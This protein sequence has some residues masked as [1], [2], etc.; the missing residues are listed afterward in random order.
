MYSRTSLKARSPEGGGA[1]R[2]NPGGVRLGRVLLQRF[3]CKCLDFLF[4]SDYL[5]SVSVNN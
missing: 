4:N 5:S 1:L 2:E 3:D